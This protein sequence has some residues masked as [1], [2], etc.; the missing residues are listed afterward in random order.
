MMEQKEKNNDEYMIV[1]NHE[2]IRR[3]IDNY[4]NHAK[5]LGFKIEGYGSIAAYTQLV[6]T[7]AQIEHNNQVKRRVGEE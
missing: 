3:E 7:V 2:E 6:A 1:L 5:A 4:I